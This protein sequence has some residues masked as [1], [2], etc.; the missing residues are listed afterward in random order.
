MFF[1]CLFFKF[2]I[3]EVD[4]C[5]VSIDSGKEEAFSFSLHV[6][7][8]LMESVY[9]GFFNHWLTF[10]DIITLITLFSVRI[11]LVYSF[12]DVLVFDLFIIG[13]CSNRDA[14]SVVFSSVCLIL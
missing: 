12:V 7:L 10:L 13:G 6:S 14:N 2:F 1:G 9:T 8:S 4:I 11:F 5:F 3:A